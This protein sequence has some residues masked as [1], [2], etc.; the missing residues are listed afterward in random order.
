MIENKKKDFSSFVVHCKKSKYDVYIGRPS[1][2]GNPFSHKEGTK[3][4][5]KTE[6][7]E[8]AVAK[9]AE[10]LESQE[11]ILREIPS[12]KGKILGCWCSPG[13][14]HGLILAELANT[15]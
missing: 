4:L 1:P 14:C 15:E 11:D 6:T 10:W 12:L 3:A 8:E 7:V 2:F 5:Y 9:Y 13:L